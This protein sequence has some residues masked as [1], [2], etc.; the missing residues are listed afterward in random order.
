MIAFKYR[1]TGSGWAECE[2]RIGQH[3]VT[4]TASYL[5]DPLPAML[6]GLCSILEGWN[7][8]QWSF[9]EEPGQFRWLVERHPGDRLRCRVYAMA[10]SF[11]HRPND[12]GELLFDAEADFAEFM[13]A[14]CSG[15]IEVL[16][17]YGERQYAERWARY[18]FPTTDLRRFE[19]LVSSL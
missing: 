9:E 8:A 11:D 5:S 6:K 7:S 16:R 19:G 15:V 4:A 10:E 17:T 2:L 13:R 12:A 3:A 18:P 14:V 1:L